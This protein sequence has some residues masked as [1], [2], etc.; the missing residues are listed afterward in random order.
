M[1]PPGLAVEYRY[2]T[3]GISQRNFSIGRVTR[4]ST[5]AAEAPGMPTKMSIIGTLIC[6]SSSR[7]SMRTEK[8]PSSSEAATAMGVSLESMN[9]DAM[10]PAKPYF[11]G[12]GKGDEALTGGSPGPGLHAGRRA[13]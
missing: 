8:R 11:A 1:F 5:S 6:G 4:F 7:G 12:S 9:S 13:G 3:P 10:R 2:S